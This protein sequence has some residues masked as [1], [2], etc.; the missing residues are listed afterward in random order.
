MFVFY[1]TLFYMFLCFFFFM[2]SILLI[3]SF[4]FITYLVS[5][6]LKLNLLHMGLSN[7]LG[8]PGKGLKHAYVMPGTDL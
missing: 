6:Y 7:A 4:T 1:I 3:P 5:H 2:I 8:T